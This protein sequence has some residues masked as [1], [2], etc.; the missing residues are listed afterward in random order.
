MSEKD[1]PRLIDDPE[2]GS[3]LRA[4][5]DEA[6]SPERLAANARGLDATIGQLPPPG[7][8][9]LGAS[10]LT[11]GAVAAVVV[12]ARLIA[13]PA[14]FGDETVP[15]MTPPPAET[16]AV[17]LA[18]SDRPESTPAIAT[19]TPLSTLQPAPSSSGTFT[20]LMTPATTRVPTPTPVMGGTLADELR[21]YD[22]ARA[23]VRRGEHAA[24]LASLD[25]L[26]RRFPKSSL[27]PE[28]A[29]TRAEVL[30]AAGR[31]DEASSL[32]SRLVSEPAHAGRRAELLRTLGDVE[33][34]RGNCTAART[35][36]RASLDAGAAGEEASAVRRG[37]GA[38][39]AD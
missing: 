18:T 27:A 5:R 21:L 20:R 9:P 12:I 38:C 14:I 25:E 15:A 8:L 1:L 13:G 22:E 7:N 29:I 19:A 28:A 31:L 34:A 35:H 2:L 26:A 32:L 16:T 33:R 4:A 10:A 6:M 23:F 17:A 39:E 11:L 37:L 36:Y 3:A 24:A 30:V